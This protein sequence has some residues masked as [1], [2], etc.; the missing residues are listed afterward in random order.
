MENLKN[1]M[2]INENILGAPTLNKVIIDEKMEQV[3]VHC[4]ASDSYFEDM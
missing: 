4:G 1:V 2:E 3:R